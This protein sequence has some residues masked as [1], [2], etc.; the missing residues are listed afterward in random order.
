MSYWCQMEYSRDLANP[1]AEE[2]LAT[3]APLAQRCSATLRL[4][5]RKT[6]RRPPGRPSIGFPFTRPCLVIPEGL[7]PTG[8]GRM[9]TVEEPS[10]IIDNQLVD[11]AYLG[12]R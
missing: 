5:R 12:H 1:L 8:G 4:S 9:G 6:L 11:M 10:R 7:L 2:Q 3:V